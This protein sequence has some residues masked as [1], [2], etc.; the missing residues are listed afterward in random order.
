[1]LAASPKQELLRKCKPM[2]AKHADSARLNEL[3]R[4]VIGSAFTVL[5]MLG[6]GFLEE[7][8]ENALA[9]ELRK[10]GLAIA[11]QCG[12][13]VT[14]DGVVVGEHCVDLLVGNGVLVEL[15]T[16]KVLVG[17]HRLQCV[18]YLKATE[19]QLG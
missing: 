1:L 4:V 18:N 13:I 5:N 17:A 8:Y 2:H 7:V 15:K 12:T 16:E 10:A 3:S 14:Y 11:Q 6:T 19:R 9:H